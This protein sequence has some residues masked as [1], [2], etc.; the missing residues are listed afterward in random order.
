MLVAVTVAPVAASAAQPACNEYCYDPIPEPGNPTDNNSGSNP[1]DNNGS[2]NYVPP[3]SSAETDTNSALDNK[4]GVE[5]SESDNADRN[6]KDGSKSS[7]KK[8]SKGDEE[9]SDEQLSGALSKVDPPSGNDSSGGSSTLGLILI[10][11]LSTGVVLAVYF[12][13]R[14]RG[15][16]PAG[17]TYMRFGAL[18]VVIV[19]L[20]VAGTGKAFAATTSASAP[21][22]FFGMMSVNNLTEVDAERMVRGGVSTYRFPIAWNSVQPNKGAEY[23]WTGPDQ[24]IAAAAKNRL[25]MLPIMLGTPKGYAGRTTVV[26]VNNASQVAGWKEFI[27]NAIRRYGP[28]GEFWAENPELPKS[29]IRTWQIWNEANFHYFTTPV[30]PPKYTKLLR[31]SKLILNKEDPNAQL[32]LTGL[33]GSPKDIPGK[34]MKSYKYLQKLYNLKADRYFD[35]VAI[36]PYTPS[37]GQLKA[38]MLRVRKTLNRNGAR[39]TPIH[40]TEIGWGS[41]RR[42]VFGMKTPAGQ[43]KQLKSGYKA[44]FRLRNKLKLRSA[45]WFAWQDV[46]S[47]EVTCNFCYSSGLF[48]PGHPLRPKPAWNAF[49]SLTGGKR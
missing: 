25:K 41:D 15:K 45:Y 35:S 17:G 32:M 4:L 38:L 24:M 46:P 27:R 22:S 31:I 11:A 3:A 44:L 1:S 47:N 5:N 49:V 23:N 10:L 33:Y 48:K 34:A 14:S 21:K 19:F 29:P 18:G 43:A 40:I 37:T 6:K 39:R 30:S 42:T 8:N 20:A 13:S 2:S 26:P 9:G 36:H 16:V 12:V 7:G 28:N